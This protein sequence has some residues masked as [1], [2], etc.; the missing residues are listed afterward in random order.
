[1]NKALNRSRLMRSQSHHRL[2]FCFIAIETH[3]SEHQ[4]H[5]VDKHETGN[6][7]LNP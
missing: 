2:T 3:L 4:L 1:M 6:C 5:I 7:Q